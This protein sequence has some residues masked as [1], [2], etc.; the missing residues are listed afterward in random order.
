MG[1]DHGPEVVVDGAVQACRELGIEVILVGDEVRI[2]DALLRL[3]AAEQRGVEVR[4]ASQAVGADEAPSQA[5][6]K[7]KDASIRVAL[8]LMK[9]GEADAALSAGHS[10]AVLAAALLV[11]GRLPSVERP[12]I[13][14][15]VPSQPAPTVLLDA[16]ANVDGKPLHLAQFALLGEVYARRILRV[17]RPRVG[18]LSNG[19]ETTKGTILTRSAMEILGQIPELALEG[20][21]EANQ[22]FSGDFDVIA[23]D[24]FTG[25]VA[26]KAAEGTALAFD[27]SLR[28]RLGSS[29]LSRLGARLVYPTLE[30]ARREFDPAEYGGAP[31][32]GCDGTVFLA[33]GDSG[34]RAIRNG[35]RAADRAASIDV[36]AEFTDVCTRVMALQP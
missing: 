15:L 35:I 32:V 22:I 30:G 24:G 25:N 21:A 13:L 1:G 7:K 6:R 28:E 2:R 31:L 36:R 17:P 9:A 26:L 4:H 8:E 16:G 3:G 23:T 14:A 34:A 20:Y 18:I 27:R 5:I 10:G 11:L 33:H 19:G 29:M 12:A